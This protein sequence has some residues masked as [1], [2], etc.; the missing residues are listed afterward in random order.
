[1]AEVDNAKA[2]IDLTNLEFPA[3]ALGSLCNGRPVV[4]L[5]SPVNKEF[6]NNEFAV[7]VEKTRHEGRGT[8]NTKVY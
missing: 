1:M 5:D 8:K 7:F 2:F 6:I 4:V 3:H